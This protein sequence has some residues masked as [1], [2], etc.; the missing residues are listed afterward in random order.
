MVG[1]ESAG[2]HPGP[3]CY[4]KGGPVTVTDANLVLGRLLPQFFPKIFG[5]DEN[6]ALDYDGAVKAFQVE[7]FIDF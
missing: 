2:A 1:P 5:P 7:D 3:V 6:E 4:R